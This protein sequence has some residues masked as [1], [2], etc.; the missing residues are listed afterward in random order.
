MGAILGAAQALVL[1]GRVRHPW[2]WVTANALGWVVAMAVIFTGST[3]AG[4]SWSSRPVLLGYGA[5][6]GAAA[7]VASVW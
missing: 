6:T 5:L 2:R 1:R 7:G 4:A 3:T